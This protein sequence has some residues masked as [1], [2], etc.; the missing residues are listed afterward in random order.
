MSVTQD[1]KILTLTVA[2]I[3][4]IRESL[5]ARELWLKDLL[6]SEIDPVVSQALSKMLAPVQ[7]AFAKAEA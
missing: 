5:H 4:A 2:E 6:S 3:C 1:Y 7:S